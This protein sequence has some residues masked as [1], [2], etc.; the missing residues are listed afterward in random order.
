MSSAHSDVHLVSGV[1]Y[2]TSTNVLNLCAAG[3]GTTHKYPERRKWECQ[4]PV[5]GLYVAKETEL[6]RR[7]ITLLA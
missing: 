4:T 2:G 5:V 3:Q 7:D 1:G 6:R